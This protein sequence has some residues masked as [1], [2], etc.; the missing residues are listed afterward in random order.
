MMIDM[1]KMITKQYI[2]FL[3]LLMSIHWASCT[4]K[5]KELTAEEKY[6][7]DTM[8]SNRVSQ[9]RMEADSLCKIYTSTHFEN[10]RDSLQ[11]ETM[12]E[13][14]LLLNKKMTEE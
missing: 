14:E 4:T 11:D 5:G 1:N 13:I 3:V 10:V 8:Y 7:V 9:Y 12:I 2:T 6:V